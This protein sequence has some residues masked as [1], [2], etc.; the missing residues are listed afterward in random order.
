MSQEFSA[1][2][3]ASKVKT[4][5]GAPYRIERR[6]KKKRGGEPLSAYA[7]D[8]TIRVNGDEAYFL[9]DHNSTRNVMPHNNREELVETL[10]RELERN[11]LEHFG[12]N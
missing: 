6:T 12:Q 7:L 4:K 8:I 1:P 9:Q 10:L 5:D 11:H 3:K 2:A